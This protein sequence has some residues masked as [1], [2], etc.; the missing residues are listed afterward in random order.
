MF[1]LNILRTPHDHDRPTAT[2]ASPHTYVALINNILNV[3][4]ELKYFWLKACMH[5]D[6]GG[7]EDVDNH[8]DSFFFFISIHM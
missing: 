2:A 8:F 7:C 6:D 1:W 4:L 5:D 3:A